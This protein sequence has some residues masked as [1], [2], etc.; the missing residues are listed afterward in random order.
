MIYLHNQP[1][2]MYIRKFYD[3]LKISVQVQLDEKSKPLL[4]DGNGLKGAYVF[5]QFHFHWG[6]TDDKG[7]FRLF[8]CSGDENRKLFI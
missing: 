3:F 6:S 8:S 4:M 2:Y 5:S 1:K 7:K